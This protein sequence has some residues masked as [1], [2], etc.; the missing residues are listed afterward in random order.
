MILIAI[1]AITRKIVILDSKA[2]DPMILFGV[3]FLIIALTL[4]Y[5]L[6]RKSRTG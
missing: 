1:T 4:G 6:L 3:G 2:I 5:Y